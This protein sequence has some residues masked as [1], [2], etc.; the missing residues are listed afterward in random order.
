AAFAYGDLDN[1]TKINILVPGMNSDVTGMHSWGTTAR[2][3]NDDVPGSATV[4]WFGYDSPNT[5]EEPGM[6]RAEDGAAALGDFLDGVDSLSPS[7]QTNVVAH[8]YGSTTAAQAIGSEHG[9]HGVDKFIT[10]GSAGLPDDDRVQQN[11]AS[12]PQIYATTSPDDHLASLGRT[13]TTSHSTVPSDLPG[14]VVFGSDGGV[15]ASGDPLALTR[16]HGAHS[17]ESGVLPWD[18][19]QNSGYLRDGTES[20]YN[21]KHI[22][23]TGSPGTQLN[24]PGS[25]SGGWSS[26]A[27]EASDIVDWVGDGV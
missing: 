6:S 10:V 2:D 13:A 21:V 7:A 17:G 15:D 11:L 22:L 9:G 23:D 5:T 4:T 19:G 27:R 16:G 26:A 24:G 12:G 18:D 20:F 8:S 3:I 1:A 25:H 14:T